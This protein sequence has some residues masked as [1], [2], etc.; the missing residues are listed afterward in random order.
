[1]FRVKIIVNLIRETTDY[2]FN[3]FNLSF[4]EHPMWLGYNVYLVIAC[5]GKH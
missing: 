4:V 3:Y 2:F 1:M 5:L